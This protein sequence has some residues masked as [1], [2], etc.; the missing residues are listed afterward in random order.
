MEPLTTRSLDANPTSSEDILTLLDQPP[1]RRISNGGIR[2]R[3]KAVLS[4]LQNRLMPDSAY[5]LG[6]QPAQ[7]SAYR[8]RRL[9][10][11]IR[12]AA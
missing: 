1:S 9:P 10:T 6:S 11:R 8:T 2:R 4:V 7:S 5:G 12:R 3:V